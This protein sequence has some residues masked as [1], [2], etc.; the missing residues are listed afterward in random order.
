MTFRKLSSTAQWRTECCVLGNGL[1]GAA[2]A[3]ELATRGVDCCVVGASYGE[4][5]Y[6]YASHH[7]QSRLVRGW[8]TDARWRSL[9]QQSLSKLRQLASWSEVPFFS[10]V[11]VLYGLDAA[12]APRSSADLLPSTLSVAGLLYQDRVGGVLNP[13]RY[14]GAMN[15]FATRRTARIIRKAAHRVERMGG[16]YRIT[17][18]EHEI[19][20]SYIFDAR[21]LYG[22]V[23]KSDDVITI[24]KITINIAGG[25]HA[26]PFGFVDFREEAGPFVNAYG[27][28]AY[29]FQGNL[30]MTK[31]GFTEREP[32]KLPNIEA[33]NAWFAGDYARYPYLIAAQRWIERFHRGSRAH[34]SIKPCAF[35]LT[36]NGYPIIRSEGHWLYV[37][38]CNGMG[39]QSCQA[40]AEQTVSVWQE[41]VRGKHVT[42]SSSARQ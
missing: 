10:E 42:R 7:D 35:T 25:E 38:G 9:V 32:V 2:I 37:G 20:A 36:R 1:F 12:I 23:A 27:C 11:P 34:V 30:P 29:A 41:T 4:R 14:I 5:Q 8:H 16:G 28:C 39:A 3:F 24:G 13:L 18:G 31:Y 6:Y 26:T 19:F 17:A 40:L 33:V 22:R 21:G 15:T